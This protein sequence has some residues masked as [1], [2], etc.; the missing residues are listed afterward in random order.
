LGKELLK[1]PLGEIAFV[2]Q[3]FPE[4]SLR[5]VRHWLPVIHVARCESFRR[6]GPRD[7]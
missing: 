3:Q 4:E 5:Q 7:Q 6:A 2:A 1:Q